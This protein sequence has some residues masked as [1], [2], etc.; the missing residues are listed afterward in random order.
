MVIGV[1]V[2][3]TVGSAVAVGTIIGVAVAGSTTV[4][5]TGVAIPSADETQLV[6]RSAA[7][8]NPVAILGE[9]RY[10]YQNSLEIFLSSHCNIPTIMPV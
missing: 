9:A 2:G 7:R 3:M 6:K 5:G 8:V 10:I 1:T 4:V